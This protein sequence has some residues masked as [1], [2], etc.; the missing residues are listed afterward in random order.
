MAGTE[1]GDKEIGFL[2]LSCER[3]LNRDSLTGI[4]DK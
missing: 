3:I 1:G 2:D 4:I